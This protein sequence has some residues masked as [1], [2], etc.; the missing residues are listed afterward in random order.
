MG[1]VIGLSSHMSSPFSESDDDAGGRCCKEQ[2]PQN[3]AVVVAGF[4]GTG[5][6]VRRSGT[7]SAAGITGAAAA[8]GVVTRGIT[9]GGGILSD[10]FRSCQLFFGGIGDGDG[11]L[12]GK[13]FRQGS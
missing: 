6:G 11:R 8:G 3:R 9:A 4:G 10:G 5:P 2:S 13:A 1:S 12:I 7:S